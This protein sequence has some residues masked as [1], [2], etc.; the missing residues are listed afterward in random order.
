M[1]LRVLGP[2]EVYDGERC[3]IG[4]PQQRR[5]LAVLAMHRG[6]V[7]TVDQLAEISWP[8]D[9]PPST[10]EANLRTYV[11]RLRAGMGDE[12]GRRIVTTPGGYVLEV[13][14]DEIDAARFEGGITRTDRLL[15]HRDAVA[16]LHQVDEALK[17]WRGDPYGM[18]SGEPWAEAEVARLID[19]RA[20][21]QELRCQAL[22]DLDRNDDAV[23]AAEALIDAHPYRERPRRMEMLALYRSGRQAEALRAYQRFRRL[24]VEELGVE[25][26]PGLAQL[27][28]SMLAQD[29]ALGDTHVAPMLRSYQPQRVIGEGARAIVWQCTQSPLG[30][31]VAIKQLRAAQANDPDFIRRFETEAQLVASLEHPHIVPL[32]DYWREP[33]VA[34]LVFRLMSGGSLADRLRRGP[35]SGDLLL[36]LVAQVGGAL[37]YSHRCGVTHRDVRPENVLLDDEDNFYLTDFGIARRSAQDPVP[38]RSARVRRVDVFGPDLPVAGGAEDIVALGRLLLSAGAAQGVDDP[39]S[40]GSGVPRNRGDG[41]AASEVPG[42]VQE[43]AR[44]CVTDDATMRYGSAAELVSEVSQ[45]VGPGIDLRSGVPRRA[46]FGDATSLDLAAVPGDVRNPFKGLRSFLEADAGDFLGRT[47]LVE[48]LVEVLKRPGPRGR[49]LAVVGPSG[50][51]KSSVV[52]AGLVP[53]VRAGAIAGSEDWFITTMVPGARPLDELE[54]ALTRVAA[55]PPGPLSEIMAADE[56][57]IGR[58]VRMVVPDDGAEVLV[59]V[60]QFEELFTH[61]DAS[62]RH[63]FLNGLLE[64]VRHSRARLRVVITIRADFWDRPLHHPELA[65]LLGEAAVTVGPMTPP[66]LR[67]AIIGPVAAQGLEFAD[68]LV[69]RMIVEVAN[70]P[71]SLPLLQFAL[72]ELFETNVSG[73]IRASSYDEMGGVAGALAHHAEERLGALTPEGR[74]AARRVFGRLVSLGEGAD[75]TRRRVF[76]NELTVDASTRSVLEAFVA[77]RLLTVDADP[78]TRLPTVEIAH[79]SLFSSWPRLGG[80]IDE[81]RDLLRLVRRVGEAAVEWDQ[82]GRPTDQVYRG[83]RLEAAVEIASFAPPV[84]NARELAFV[85]A[86]EA[87][88]EA[89]QSRAT[90]R[91]PRSAG[92]PRRDRC[93][94]RRRADRRNGGSQPSNRR[95]P[96]PQRRRSIRGCSA[97]GPDRI[98]P[99]AAHSRGFRGCSAGGPARG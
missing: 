68:G 11:H 75:D 52:R 9:A 82:A 44:R 17:L 28:A 23:S 46:G 36:R 15:D 50:S 31:Q 12:L 67:E 21:A 13:A 6:V 7:V 95:R 59:V 29:P 8:G 20:R 84:L 30:R 1:D 62:Q 38:T 16:A 27:E 65:A 97:G 22:V 5:I 92:P 63:M 45:L 24:L 41:A 53:A 81:D 89:E 26:S 51:G 61:A 64:A 18:F 83:G 19:L 58:A 42:W 91:T 47:R 4:G 37:S 56:H 25:P 3:A 43:V 99:L 32:Y 54:A 35:L 77:A 98:G 48:R 90:R 66:E 88:E 78:V 57:G 10:A 76:V 60:D 49:L 72:T 34:F 93:V 33:D 14:D 74:E 2:V 69:E 71:G 94:P 73:L 70:Q 80:W 79:E 96:G 55:A 40:A 39:A 87:A 85:H 86:G